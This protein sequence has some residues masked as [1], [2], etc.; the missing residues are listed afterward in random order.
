M[1]A[2]TCFFPKQGPGK[3]FSRKGTCPV[4][5]TDFLD[6]PV[7]S[8]LPLPTMTRISRLT[9][10]AALL[11]AL[12]V[13]PYAFSQGDEPDSLKEDI[14]ATSDS[15]SSANSNRLLGGGED[16]T[17]LDLFK[18]TGYFIYPLGAFSIWALY[19][20]L[21]NLFILSEGRLVPS[22]VAARVQELLA[23][24]NLEGVEDIV[25]RRSDLLSLMVQAGLNKAGRDPGLIET[26]MEGSISREIVSLHNRIRRLADIGN[27]AP[28]LGLL[29]TVW[30]MIRV[31][32]EI[33]IDSNAM[34]AN[35][36]SA[37]ADGVAL[38]MLTTVLGLVIGI[39]SLFF[40]YIYRSKMAKVVGRLEALGTDLA[41]LLSSQRGVPPTHIGG[42]ETV[43]MGAKR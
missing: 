5:F 30:G 23:A 32:K 16:I 10:A 29:G 14:L 17:L 43:L 8:S 11:L 35:W 19:L 31:F 15:L 39:P 20:I 26:S 3:G 27:L 1:V 41:D 33:S 13:L 18:K 21:A 37:L 34:V 2:A 40:Y 4:K 7:S 24:G 9:L 22:R 28:M 6:T 36:S 42:D 38:A 12:A 25:K